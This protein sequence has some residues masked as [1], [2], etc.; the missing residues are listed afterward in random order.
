MFNFNLIHESLADYRRS[1]L[2]EVISPSETM[3][4][5][6]YFEVGFS[7][8]NVIMGAIGSSYLGKVSSVLDI[9]CGHGRVTRHLKALFPNAKIT[10]C[11]IDKDG[12]SFCEKTFNVIPVVSKRDPYEIDFGCHFDLIWIGSFFTHLSEDDS[13]KWLKHLCGF[14]T[15]NGILVA[16]FHGRKSIIINHKTPY[17]NEKSWQDILSQYENKGYGYSD[18]NKSENHEYIDSSYGVSLSKAQK[19]I[20]MAQQLEDVRIYSYTEAG[21]ADHQDVLVIGKPS[22]NG[23]L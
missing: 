22:I 4:N 17:I 13:R 23:S 9:P 12:V 15:D 6:W 20:E 14:L 2:I 19:I 8:V 1:K 10:A 5:K 21:W 3:L 16:T 18:Y 7:A 11:D